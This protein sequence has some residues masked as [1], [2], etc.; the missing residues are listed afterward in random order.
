MPKL[1]AKDYT[2][3]KVFASLNKGCT[4]P[5]KKEGYWRESLLKD[6]EGLPFPIIQD[7][8]ENVDLAKFTIRLQKIEGKKARLLHYKGT[9]THRHTGA[10]NGSGEYNYKGW[11]WPQGY[12]TYLD[13][14]VLPSR[15]F[16]AFIM[17]EPKLNIALPNLHVVIE[18]KIV[19]KKNAKPEKAEKKTGKKDFVVDKVYPIGNIPITDNTKLRCVF[20]EKDGEVKGDLRIWYKTQ[21][22]EEFAPSPK[23]IS[24]SVS[25][26]KRVKKMLS[27]A[28][29]FAETQGW[30]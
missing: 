28:I 12:S 3:D 27:K 6:E 22:M 26:M 17:D 10:S 9:S 1:K 8:P 21:K 15:K 7:Q 2:G 19:A 23:G 5:E 20:N 4:F 16:Y 11:F 18:D 13:A 30:E 29:A 14:G 25:E 24:M